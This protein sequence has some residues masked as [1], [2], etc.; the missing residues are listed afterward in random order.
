MASSESYVITGEDMQLVADVVAF[1][2]DTSRDGSVE[3]SA[4]AFFAQRH[5]GLLA[6][7]QA[8]TAGEIALTH[9]DMDL[10]V[11]LSEREF[12]L[13]LSAYKTLAAQTP[14]LLDDWRRASGEVREKLGESLVDRLGTTPVKNEF[15]G[16]EETRNVVRLMGEWLIFDS[17]ATG[18]RDLDALRGKKGVP[19]T[20]L[21]V[22]KATKSGALQDAGSALMHLLASEHGVDATVFADLVRLTHLDAPVDEQG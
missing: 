9:S 13:T 6:V 5:L 2:Q 7:A 22:V 12:T 11:S 8:S 19:A 20:E 3:A 10:L 1:V 21:G 4:T 18:L 16:R 14:N 17:L 15:D